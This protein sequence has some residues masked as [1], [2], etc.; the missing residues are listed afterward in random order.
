MAVAQVHMDP[1]HR[2]PDQ[3][4]A[5]LA[6]HRVSATWFTLAALCS[7]LILALSVLKGAPNWLSFIYAGV[8]WALLLIFAPY[9]ETKPEDRA[10]FKADNWYARLAL[11]KVPVTYIL[12][13][14]LASAVILA[15]SLLQGLPTW[16][17]FAL[18]LSP[19]GAIIF[20]ELEWIY[21]HFGWFTLFATMATVQTIHYSEHCIEVIQ[22]HIFHQTL[23]QSIAI[24]SSLNV[25]LVHFS[26][27]SFLT[28]GT[29]LLLAKYP[30]NPFL[31]IAIPFQIAHQAEHTYLTYNYLFAGDPGGGV[32]L[33]GSPGGAIGGGIGL[34]RPDLH[35]V[36]NTLYTI[37]FVSALIYQTKHIYD[38][39]LKKAFPHLST[40]ALIGLGRK[41]ETLHFAPGEVILSPGDPSDR[42]YI[43]SEG[44]AA[45]YST[46]ESGRDVESATLHAGQYF[47]EIGLLVPDAPHTKTIRAVTKLS[48]LEMEKETFLAIIN[49]SQE[50]GSDMLALAKEHMAR[51]QAAASG[52]ATV[53]ARA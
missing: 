47:G 8:P 29:L 4:W 44:S 35:W 16:L 17:S 49:S 2:H 10:T 53:P 40:A 43:I 21:A 15:L 52:P 39:N 51:L 27:D 13:A 32:G 14:S 1:A 5:K 50:T 11:H 36:Y 28:I 37:P 6:I 12:A 18:A 19:W 3:W 42:L 38:A 41:V 23:A 20:I 31:W 24:F 26:G 48:V 45:V 33:L 46:D 30:R 7:Y 25:E 22:Y 9:I 34:N